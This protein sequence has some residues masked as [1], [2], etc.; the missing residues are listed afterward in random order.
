M[1]ISS[2]VLELWLRR[3]KVEKLTTKRDKYQ[4]RYE[5]KK[6]LAATAVVMCLL[7]S[8]S[9]AVFA[10]PSVTGEYSGLLEMLFSNIDYDASILALCAHGSLDVDFG[11]Y[12]LDAFHDIL[13]TF[14]YTTGGCAGPDPNPGNPDMFLITFDDGTVSI[15]SLTE[16]QKKYAQYLPGAV[17]TTFVADALTGLFDIFYNYGAQG[18]YATST[19]IVTAEYIHWLETEVE[20]FNGFL[21]TL[22]AGEVG[23]GTLFDGMGAY[24]PPDVS[25]LV[26]DV[27]GTHILGDFNGLAIDFTGNL[28]DFDFLGTKGWDWWFDIDAVGP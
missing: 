20:N 15:A 9:M 6:R 3:W 24:S 12:T 17:Q 25:V 16:M 21:K 1:G 7:A 26:V 5:M 23:V 4:G 19:E 2:S 14:E 8:F 22:A 27:D 18:D 10:G 11:S 28:F 13:D